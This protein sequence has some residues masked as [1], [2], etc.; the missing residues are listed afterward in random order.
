MGGLTH[1]LFDPHDVPTSTTDQ[2]RLAL[3]EG[4]SCLVAGMPGSG[5]SHA[6]RK[7]VNG[8]VWIDVDDSPLRLPKFFC[9]AARQVPC[10]PDVLRALAHDDVD[11]A[12]SVLS[13]GL[14]DTPL[15]VDNAERLTTSVDWGWDEP[16]VALFG[17]YSQQ[18]LDWILARSSD[19]PTVLVTSRPLGDRPNG[20][21][22][23]VKHRPPQSWSLKLRAAPSFRDWRALAT[24]H[25]AMNPGGLVIAALA[26]V[27]LSPSAYATILKELRWDVD[28]GGGATPLG[29]MRRL[30]ELLRA[31]MPE[32]WQHALVVADGLDGLDSA[33]AME[34]FTGFPEARAA[35][36]TFRTL[37]LVVEHNGRA[38]LLPIARSLGLTVGLRDESTDRCLSAA[39][40]RLLESVN[41]HSSFETLSAERVFR[42][43]AL[44]V[45]LGDTPNAQRTA[46]LH[47]SGLIDLARRTSLEERWD[48]AR[49]L[50][51]HI[52]N[53]LD[54]AP[55][56]YLG[57]RTKSYVVHYWAYN[58]RRANTIPRGAALEGYLVATELWP[59]NALWRK[60]L[61]SLLIT[62]G[63]TSEAGRAVTEAEQH[64]PEH[65]HRAAMLR[66]GPAWTALHAGA[67]LFALELVEV[68]SEEEVGQDPEGLAS[69]RDFYD[70]WRA[71]VPVTEVTFERGCVVLH[72]P[73][74]LAL[75]R[76]PAQQGW[77]AEWVPL[78]ATGRGT[79]PLQAVRRS[80]TAVAEEAAKLVSTPTHL[81]DDA[82]VVRKSHL[83]GTIDL[84][85]SRI[86]LAGSGHRWLLGKFDGVRFAPVQSE[87]GFLEVCPAG[88]PTIREGLFFGRVPVGM[89]GLPTDPVDRIQPAGSGRS[90]IELLRM[91]RTLPRED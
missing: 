43:H 17:G 72:A 12:W 69:L 33:L 44:Y 16:T 2:V 27:L 42:A 56:S 30:V 46:R 85:A 3:S 24:D 4:S 50:Y 29:T 23:V 66:L 10:G 59:N 65:P 26:V 73:G 51:E 77:L 1:F 57:Q 38:K 18:L 88:L 11:Q 37:G 40:G 82:T 87:I 62:L 80:A 74:R 75:R 7:A 67:E 76:L 61:I 91:A 47:T 13:K 49:R 31:H 36:E 89:D 63:R 15:V 5:K 14:G 64:V 48:E 68:V 9:D 39:A 86:G 84:V 90:L 53:M 8:A 21:Q 79:T 81:L 78:Q 52:R 41:D 83:I 22:R 58:G 28:M 54:D 19:Q 32:S 55:S 20:I 35:Y 25:L 6:V 60:R 70:H 71:G 34:A 45:T